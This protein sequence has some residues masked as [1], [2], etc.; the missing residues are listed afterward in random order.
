MY[1]DGFRKNSKGKIKNLTEEELYDF[2]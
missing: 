2:I 1:A